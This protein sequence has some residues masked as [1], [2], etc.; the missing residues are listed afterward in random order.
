MPLQ[1][2][3]NPFG[4]IIETPARGTMM[5]NRGGAIHNDRRMIVRQ[6]KGQRWIACVLEF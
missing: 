6:F 5:G 3:V 1:N 4:A 2:R